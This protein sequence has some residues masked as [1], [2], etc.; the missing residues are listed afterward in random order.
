MTR[1]EVIALYLFFQTLARFS[2][3]AGK[4][5][6]SDHGHV[7]LLYDRL[8]AF[9]RQAVIRRPRWSPPR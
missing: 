4:G 8:D 2:H 7:A 6:R 9:Y 5:A 1:P 3:I